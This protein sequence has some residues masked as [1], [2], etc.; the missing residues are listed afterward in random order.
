MQAFD[1]EGCL[2]DEE[3]VAELEDCF[4]EFKL[5]V[6][7]TNRLVSEYSTAKERS[8]KIFLGTG[9]RKRGNVHEI[10]RYDRYKCKEID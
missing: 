6:E 9:I 4:N 3:K 7:I 1:E 5:F 8:K 2:K 10:C